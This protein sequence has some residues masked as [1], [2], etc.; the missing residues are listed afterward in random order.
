MDGKIYF[1][2]GVMGSGKTMNLATAAFNFVEKGIPILV[3]KPGKDTRSTKIKS[4]VPGVQVDC[5]NIPE[6]CNVYNLVAP[7]FNLKDCSA[8]KVNDVKNIRPDWIIADEAQFFTKEQIDQFT[9]IADEFGVNIIFYGL[10][11]DFRGEMFEGSKRILEVADKYEE[12]K[13]AC[14]CGKKATINARV[15]DGYVTTEGEQVVVG[16]NE[17]YAPLCRKCWK[18]HIKYHLPVEIP[19][20]KNNLNS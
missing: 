9:D 8:K 14:F 18:R 20:V 7:M 5:I 10:R 11:T 2:Y 1:R 4:R 12:M 17:M 6:D 13:S 15:I 16:A 19:Q 3:M